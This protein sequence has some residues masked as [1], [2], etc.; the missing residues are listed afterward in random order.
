M[1][2]P[3]SAMDG[4]LKTRTTE[5]GG[6]VQ[7][8]V[9]DISFPE[10]LIDLQHEPFARDIV[11]SVFF[12]TDGIIV[13]KRLGDDYLH[14]KRIHKPLEE[15]Q[16]LGKHPHATMGL[17]GKETGLHGPD[18]F[19]DVSAQRGEAVIPARLVDVD[20]VAGRIGILDDAE[21][22]LHLV[23]V[24]VGNLEK[25]YAIPRIGRQTRLDAQ[26]AET[27]RGDEAHL[28]P[29]V[30]TFEGIRGYGKTLIK[31]RREYGA[32]DPLL[33][34][35]FKG[36]NVPQGKQLPPAGIFQMPVAGKPS[37]MRRL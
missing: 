29:A 16:K 8:P 6:A 2:G 14:A 15:S 33:F 36:I 22:Q 30:R 12:I 24:G 31:A 23:V 27:I 1:N 17:I 11:E 32:V 4:P 18:L 10:P 7:P 37:H 25:E 28:A 21:G 34:S 35:L 20:I 26:E 19:R 5:R 9:I 13:G 3:A